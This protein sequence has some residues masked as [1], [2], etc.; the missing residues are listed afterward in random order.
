MSAVAAG[1]QRRPLHL[2]IVGILA[3]LWNAGGAFDYVM[4]QTGNEAYMAA[5]TAEQLDYFYGFPVWA[6]A[7]WAIAVWAAVAGSV[8]LLLRRRLA[9]PVF[10]LSLVAMLV[11]TVYTSLSGGWAMMGSAGAIAFS[12]AIYVVGIALWLYARMMARKGVLV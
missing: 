12:G 4:T 8:L 5:F 1:P 9:E 3:L 2:W 6:T 11:N 10:L 7:S